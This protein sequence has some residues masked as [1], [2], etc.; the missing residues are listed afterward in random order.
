MPREEKNSKI[1]DR[2]TVHL[3]FAVLY[4]IDGDFLREA[5]SQLEWNAVVLLPFVSYYT[6][7]VQSLP[8]VSIIEAT[9]DSIPLNLV[10]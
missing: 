9:T 6:L 1:Y 8:E 7:F 2:Y 3:Q 10:L 5:T 4:G